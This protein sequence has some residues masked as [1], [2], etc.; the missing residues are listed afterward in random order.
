M[1]AD[2][3][4]HNMRVLNSGVKFFGTLEL[5]NGGDEHRQLLA[6]AIGNLS[7]AGL[8]RNRGFGRIR[9]S[10]DAKDALIADFFDAR[11]L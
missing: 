11:G 2:G 3:S 10:F 5:R 7:A 6:L 8:K 1:A 4:L 9:C